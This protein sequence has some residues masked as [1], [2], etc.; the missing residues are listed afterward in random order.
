MHRMPL[1]TI[2]S[3]STSQV[4]AHEESKESPDASCIISQSLQGSPHLA[5]EPRPSKPMS[6]SRYV[7]HVFHH[8][9][10]TPIELTSIHIPAMSS[11][12]TITANHSNKTLSDTPMNIN[13]NPH[14]R[15]LL[16][17]STLR[18]GPR[19]RP[20]SATTSPTRIPWPRTSDNAKWPKYALRHRYLAYIILG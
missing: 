16:L 5:L 11:I 12:T 10:T 6:K 7:T 4:E 3:T 17:L 9:C 15:T 8:T 19:T 2:A 18:S 20:A 13:D 14:P 1:H